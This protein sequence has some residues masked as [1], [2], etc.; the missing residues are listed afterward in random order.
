MP[1]RRCRKNAPRM[2]PRV[3]DERREGLVDEDLAHL[4]ARAHHAA[5]EEEELRGQDDAGERDAERGA[6]GIV[7]KPLKASQTYCGAKI[8]PS[9]M[10]PPRTTSMVVRMTES[11]RSPPSSS[12]AS[13]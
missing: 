13:R 3:V 1:R 5:D 4:Q 9:R 11:A 12:P 8:S 7:R 6:V 10:P 2:M